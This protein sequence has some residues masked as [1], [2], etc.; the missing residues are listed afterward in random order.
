MSS[1]YIYH[2]Y[3]KYIKYVLL[4]EYN[5]TF[6]KKVLSKFIVGV[7]E[8]FYRSKL[9]WMINS[10]NARGG[11]GIPTKPPLTTW[12]RGDFLL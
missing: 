11:E 8:I 1:L 4:Y 9:F 12:I 6:I 5:N 3:K 7:C 2:T 10:A